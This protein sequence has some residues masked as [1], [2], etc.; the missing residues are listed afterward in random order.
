MP[1]ASAFHGQAQFAFAPSEAAEKNALCGRSE[2]LS[3]SWR[4]HDKVIRDFCR[5]LTS[6]HITPTFT[7]D[8]GPIKFRSPEPGVKEVSVLWHDTGILILILLA[9]TA[10]PGFDAAQSKAS[11]SF[12]ILGYIVT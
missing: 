5:L 9:M 8:R 4:A 7:F 3:Q 1:K 10:I 2:F 6:R 11:I 12:S